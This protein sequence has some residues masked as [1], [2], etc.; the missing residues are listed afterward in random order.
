MVAPEIRNTGMQQVIV[1]TGTCSR[2]AFVDAVDRDNATGANES[3]RRR[4]HPIAQMVIACVDDILCL[5]GND[6]F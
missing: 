4:S 2:T 1:D 6:S 5:V 3:H